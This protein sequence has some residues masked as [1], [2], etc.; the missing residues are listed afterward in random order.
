MLVQSSSD[1]RGAETVGV[2]LAGPSFRYS[3][4]AAVA[5][6]QPGAIGLQFVGW[7]GPIERPVRA[8]VTARLRSND[9]GKLGITAPRIQDSR[10]HQRAAIAGL[11]A[12]IEESPAASTTRHQ[13]LN[14]GEQ[15]MLINDLTQQ[16]ISAEISFV[17]TGQGIDHAGSARVAHQTDSSAGV[18]ITHWDGAPEAIRAL[19]SPDAKPR[20]RPPDAYITEW[21]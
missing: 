16:P 10:T 12:L 6:R 14:I 19:I 4:V 5:H 17:L 9:P 8:L 2:E 1:L 7:D 13:V 21:S 11:S 18:A 20:P 15:G 3:G